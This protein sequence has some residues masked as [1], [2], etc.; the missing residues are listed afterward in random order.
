MH[1]FQSIFERGGCPPFLNMNIRKNIHF[2]YR[3]KYEDT[4]D[5]RSYTHNL[6]SCEIKA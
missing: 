1:L 4:I 6:S 5:H 2:N 3:E